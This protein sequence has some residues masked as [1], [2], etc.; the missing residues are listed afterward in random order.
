MRP[1]RVRAPRAAR[2]TSSS[3]GA[4]LAGCAAGVQSPSPGAPEAACLACTWLL[5]PI[6]QLVRRKGTSKLQVP[7]SANLATK[8]GHG[9]R[10]AQGLPRA[11]CLQWERIP[12]SAQ[13]AKER[14]LGADTHGPFGGTLDIRNPALGPGQARRCLRM[15]AQARGS[16]KGAAGTGRAGGKPGL[17]L[18]RSQEQE[19]AE[20]GEVFQA[21]NLGAAPNTRSPGEKAVRTEVRTFSRPPLPQIE[22]SAPST[23]VSGKER[24]CQIAPH[25]LVLDWQPRTV[26]LKLKLNDLPSF[27]TAPPYP[28]PLLFLLFKQER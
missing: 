9:A 10:F 20:P 21:P 14:T 12:G 13:G 18:R 7:Q 19:K 6:L 16:G 28:P 22:G 11:E 4:G 8:R 5:R 2:G 27:P 23:H 26:A 15:H 25:P 3:D 24:K 1:G 17:K